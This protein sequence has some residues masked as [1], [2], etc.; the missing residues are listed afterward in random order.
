MGERPNSDWTAAKNGAHRVTKGGSTMKLLFGCV[1]VFMVIVAGRA[2]LAG[3]AEG[4]IPAEQKLFLNNHCT[5]CH[6]IK[7]VK[8]EK[9]VDPAEEVEVKESAVKEP[10]AKKQ[11]PDLSGVGLKHKS[12]WIQG[13]LL[14]KELID[15]KPHKKKFRGTSDELKTLAAWLETLKTKPVEEPA[16]TK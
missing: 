12:D 10:G 1:A 6:S 7:A 9:K 13:W 5:S 14:K 15:G 16:A 11:P 2:D 3:A 4:G 8:V